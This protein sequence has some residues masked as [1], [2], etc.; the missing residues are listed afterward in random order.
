MKLVSV[1]VAST[2]TGAHSD[3]LVIASNA[4]GPEIYSLLCHGVKSLPL[5]FVTD[6][7]TDGHETK[8]L[9]WR[10]AGPV[11]G[12]PELRLARIQWDWSG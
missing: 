12:E 11:W 2:K 10:H 9:H 7:Q 5:T 1:P 4:R 8:I 3:C 6:R